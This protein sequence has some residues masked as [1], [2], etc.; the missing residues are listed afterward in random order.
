MNIALILG[1]GNGTRMGNVSTPKQ[2]L[3]INGKPLI[4]HTIE[5]FQAHDKIDLIVIVTG[6]K[7]IDNVTEY[8]NVFN[9]NKV[10]YI[11]EGGSTRQESSFNGLKK[12]KEFATD[13]DLVLIHDAAR[14]M[15]NSRIISDNIEVANKYS[16]AITVIPSTDTIVISKDHQIMDEVPLRENLYKAQTPQSFQFKLI[17]EAHDWALKNNIIDASDDCQ[18]V[19]RKGFNVHLVNGETSNIKI[20]TFDDLLIVKAL[21]EIKK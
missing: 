1:A 3:N 19:K 21:L 20:T 7:Y 17:Y 5:A 13:N 15:I 16:A 14:P 2:Y 18:L 10:K 11:V 12:I 8:V 9:L 6:K 4:V